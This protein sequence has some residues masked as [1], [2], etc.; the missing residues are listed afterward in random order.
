MGSMQTCAW[1]DWSDLGAP[2]VDH[3]GV[4]FPQLHREPGIY[5][6]TVDVDADQRVYIGETDNL[7]RRFAGYRAPG[8]TQTTNVRMNERLRRVASAGGTSRVDVMTAIR[9][10]VDGVDVDPDLGSPFVRRYL[11][12]A[13]LIEEMGRHG[14]LINGR[15]YGTHRRHP[16]L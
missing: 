7:Q 9:L 15:G 4:R 1:W 3:S 6:I 14:E 8:R 13:A 10:S 2:V 12:N 16:I 11:E 5:R